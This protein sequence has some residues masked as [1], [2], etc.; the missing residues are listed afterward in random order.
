MG[1][2]QRLLVVAGLSAAAISEISERQ[3]VRKSRRRSGSET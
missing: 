3:R 2:T 1:L